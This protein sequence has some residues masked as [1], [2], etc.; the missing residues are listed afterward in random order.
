MQ[1][2]DV[3]SVPFI[4]YESTDC[5]FNVVGG[6]RLEV[7]GVCETD[8]MRH[9]RRLVVGPTLLRPMIASSGGGG[10]PEGSG[11]EGGTGEPSGSSVSPAR[12]Y[13]SATMSPHGMKVVRG[14]SSLLGSVF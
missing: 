8:R 7:G 5:T 3:H 10:I 9:Q 14:T 11:V 2:V 4:S 12:R 13:A 1:S 6:W